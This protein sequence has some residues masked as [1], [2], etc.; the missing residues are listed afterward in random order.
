MRRI[1]LDLLLQLN[2]SERPLW[3]YV[4]WVALEMICIAETIRM[5]RM[6]LPMTSSGRIVRSRRKVLF[7]WTHI[8]SS[9]LYIDGIYLSES[10]F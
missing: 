3:C 6:T 5:M 4:C 10:L 7:V 1:L 9:K 8:L 2:V